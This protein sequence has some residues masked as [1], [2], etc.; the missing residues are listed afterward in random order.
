MPGAADAE[1][2]FIA[3]MMVLILVISFVAVF[4][5]VRQYKKEMA[6]KAE[7][8]KQ[9]AEAKRSETEAAEVGS[10]QS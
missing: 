10:E 4:F 3:A 6:E 1:L 2:Y 8:L 5:F 9:K 7:R